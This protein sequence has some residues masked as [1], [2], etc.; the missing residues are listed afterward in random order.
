[1]QVLLAEIDVV[2]R[3]GLFRIAPGLT[4]SILGQSP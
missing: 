2:Q 3:V 1:M 4:H